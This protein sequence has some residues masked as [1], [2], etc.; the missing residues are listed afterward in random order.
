MKNL[1]QI[2]QFILFT[3]LIL[4]CVGPV[5]HL[6]PPK[7]E[8]PIRS[9]YIVTQSAHTGL[10]I[11]KDDIPEDLILEKRDFA[12]FQYLEFGWGDRDFYMSAEEPLSLGSK[13]AFWP[14]AS[15]L[16]V[17]GFNASVEKNFRHSEIIRIDLSLNG[18]IQLCK[19][20][21]DSFE[22]VDKKPAV[23]LGYGLYGISYFY[24]SKSTFHLFNM[25][26]KWTA[27]AL[28][29]AGCPI[30]PFYSF[31]ASNVLGQAED[32]GTAVRPK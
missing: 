15:V 32:F 3:F 22:R 25:C 5:E 31:T 8:D 10:A 9:V 20:I 24:P 30:T 27:K 1:M 14:T 23:N 16:H 7:P 29:A 26:N 17:V 19:Y 4:G 28:R 11:K 2:F 12:R 18:F 21:D 6:F 13:A